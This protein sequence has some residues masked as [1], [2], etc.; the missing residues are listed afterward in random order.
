M[1]PQDKLSFPIERE[2]SMDRKR[3]LAF[4]AKV[5]VAHVV[6]YF[7][8]GAISYRLL[9]K[10]F[11]EGSDA[12]FASFMRTA[13]EAPLWR[14]VMI[15]FIP[16]QIVRGLLIAAVL[17]PFFDT[18]KGWRFRKR[19]FS[20][21]GLYLVVGFWASAVAAPGTIDGMIYMRPEITTYAHLMVQPEIVLQG[22]AMA[23]WI[24]GWMP[25]RPRLAES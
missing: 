5:I 7:V 4:A 11:Y 14:H 22:L 1:R 18:L 10:Q 3:F 16:G 2:I 25:R 12:I 24:A 20:I 6:T 13:A 23:A 19:V 15:W 17:Y 9:T 21:A 8:V